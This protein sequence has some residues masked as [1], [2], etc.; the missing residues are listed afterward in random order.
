MSDLIFFDINGTIVER[1]DRTDLP[2]IEAANELL[3]TDNSMKNVNNAARSDM[4]VFKEILI[5]HDV[6]YTEALWRNFLEIYEKKLKEYKSTDIW[7]TNKDAKKFIEKLGKTD[8]K[9]AI[10][11][12]E[13]KIGAKFK[14]EKIGVWK[15]FPVGG[16]GED[17]ISRFGIAEV[18][19]E[20]AKKYYNESFDNI[21]VIG[22]TTLDIATARHI[23]AKIIS[24]ATGANTKKELQYYKPDYLIKRFRKIKKLFL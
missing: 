9:L 4:D 3:Y 5:N 11:T 22:D 20:K 19:L 21:Y 6:D 16:F 7:R 10:I 8:H 23:N 18:A 14:L 12:G 13:L 1:D 2:Y 17:N 24:I 15:H